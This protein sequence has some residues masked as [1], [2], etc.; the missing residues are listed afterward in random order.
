MAGAGIVFGLAAVYAGPLPP[1]HREQDLQAKDLA[2]PVVIYNR[3]YTGAVYGD[4]VPDA[5]EVSAGF[6]PAMARNEYEPMQ[7]GLYVPT[8]KAALTNI[9]LEVKCP[10]PCSIGRI[11]TIPASELS[12]EADTSEALIKTNFP[13]ST[14]PVDIKLLVNKRSSM[15]L[16]V[17]PDP[18]IA[19][20][21]PGR[22]AAFWVTF[23]TD[24]TIPPGAQ[25]GT[26]ILRVDGK[27][28]ETVPFVVDVYPFALPRPK[29]HYG[30]YYLPYM[31]AAAFQ[32]REF[33]KLYLADMT[34]HG[35]NLLNLEVPLDALAK[36][37]YNQDSSSPVDPPIVGPSKTT[38]LFLD[39]YLSSTDYMPDGGYN[40]LRLVEN[41]IRLG[42]EA[43]LVQRDHPA[44]TYNSAFSVQNKSGVLESLRAYGASREWPH[45]MLYMNDEPGPAV[46]E[47]VNRHVGEWR[48]LGATGIAAMSNLGAFGVGGVHSAWIVMAGQI[49]PEMRR[50]AERLGADLWTY[51][52]T[53]RATNF[54]LGRFDAGLYTWSL[55]LKGNIPYRYF[56]GGY[57]WNVENTMHFDADWKLHSPLELHG[58]VVA[59][60]QGPVPGVGWEG[61]RE[62]VDDVRY[63]QLLEARVDAAGKYR[64]AAFKARRWLERL[65]AR[66]YTTELRSYHYNVWGADFMRPNSRILP[67]DYHA[68]RAQAAALIAALPAAP[69]ELNP[70]PDAWVRLKPKPVEA[71]AFAKAS[72]DE[73][74][75]A[76]ARG[77]IAQQRQAAGALAIRKAEDILPAREVLIS[78]LDTPEVRMVALRALAILGADAAPALPALRTLLAHDDAFVRTGATYVLTLIGKEAAEGLA[79][80]AKDTDLSVVGLAREALDKLAK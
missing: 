18:R 56:A 4:Y 48:R 39:N 42:K 27:E 9:T 64:P 44:L 31:T 15:P 28:L 36:E 40:A 62:G 33:M 80:A 57:G 50:E 21:Q 14:F 66:S 69:G 22:S 58:Y 34:A 25:P 63:L 52:H 10:V 53:Q 61:Q 68:I 74:I 60:P 43:G 46:F 73:C 13:Y 38:R 59:G 37:G 67:E 35:R 12:W 1:V 47:E 41:Q 78:R 7:V 32:G 65:R 29:V 2:R 54:E 79:I 55:G 70:E 71:D 20:I 23:K 75:K 5:T 30:I 77:T 8:G 26:L 45:F 11:Y 24:A 49:T 19:E 16:F 17:P 76:L 6:A 51:D 3:P 72:V